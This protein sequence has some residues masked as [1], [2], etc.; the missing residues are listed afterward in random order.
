MQ[1]SQDV[2]EHDDA[3]S[4]NASLSAGWRRIVLDLLRK[5]DRRVEDTAELGIVR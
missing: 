1:A 5:L 3:I 4:S 2:G